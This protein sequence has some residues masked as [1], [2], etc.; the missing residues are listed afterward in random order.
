M[1]KTPRQKKAE[2]PADNQK[3]ASKENKGSKSPR[4]EGSSPTSPRKK[5]YEV[6]FQKKNLS[7]MRYLVKT[8]IKINMARF[9]KFYYLNFT[10]KYKAK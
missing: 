5:F 2:I 7:G 3:T 8:N 9:Q 4:K 1:S 6:I 10:Y